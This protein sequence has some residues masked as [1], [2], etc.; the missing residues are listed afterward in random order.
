MVNL[1]SVSG[2]ILCQK[3]NLSMEATDVISER[4]WFINK[5][6]KADFWYIFKAVDSY[7]S[8]SYQNLCAKKYS[9]PVES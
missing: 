3:A 4:T 2:K 1:W 6:G 8:N 5:L 7:I 9:V